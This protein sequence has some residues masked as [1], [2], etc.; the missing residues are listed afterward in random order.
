[1]SLGGGVRLALGAGTCEAPDDGATLSGEADGALMTHPAQLIS[2]PTATK[3]LA[4]NHPW[5]IPMM[6]PLA[7]PPPAPTQAIID[8]WNL[9]VHPTLRLTGEAA[10]ASS[11]RA[12]LLHVLRI[13]HR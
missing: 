5:L 2:S 13:V 7:A 9:D 11:H 4:P 6:F 12:G 8:Q 10:P 1:M 3:A